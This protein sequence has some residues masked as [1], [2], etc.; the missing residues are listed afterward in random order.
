MRQAEAMERLKIEAEHNARMHKLSAEL[1]RV[2]E[3]TPVD[4]HAVVAA[5]ACARRGGRQAAAQR[6]PLHGAARFVQ[7]L[8]H[9]LKIHRV[10]ARLQRKLADDE[11]SE[12]LHGKHL[13]SWR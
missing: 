3:A 2:R 13:L 6:A 10:S 4:A 9:Q 11:R 8:A 5:R 7:R 1:Q 12:L